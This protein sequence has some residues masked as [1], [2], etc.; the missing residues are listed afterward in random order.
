MGR[1]S[2]FTQ[3]IADEICERLSKGEPLAQICRDEHMPASRTVSD[4]K[5][6]HERF[7]ADFA[8]A[9]DDGFDAIALQCLEIAD[10]TSS[11]TIK[12]EDGERPNTEWIS[13]SKLRVETRLKLLAKWDPKRYGE[14][15]QAELTGANG[16]P[17]ET[18]TSFKL[19]PLE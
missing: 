13:R 15:L 5:A 19:A 3:E 6:E 8:R 18:A 12:T 7:A 1:R 10:E 9:R 2:T 16:G 11:D 4:W 17:I 14:K